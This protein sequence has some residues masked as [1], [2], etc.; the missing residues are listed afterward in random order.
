MRAGTLSPGAIS[1]A[2]RTAYRWDRNGTIATLTGSPVDRAVNE[3]TPPLSL[4]RAW[5]YRWMPATSISGLYASKV[6]AWSWFPAI[7]ITSMPSRGQRQQRLHD[8]P[9]RVRGRDGGVVDVAG[10]QDRVDG[11][12]AGV[13]DDLG[14]HRLVLV[15]PVA[16]LEGLPDV[17]VG[18]VEELH[19]RLL[20]DVVGGGTG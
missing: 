7:A 9:L 4:A 2:A 5:P 13:P 19:G 8:E 6:P 16:A 1:W 11:V 10:D 3:Y 20:R 12:G 15:E 14:E 18:G 17:P